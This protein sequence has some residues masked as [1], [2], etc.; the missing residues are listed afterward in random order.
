MAHL[1]VRFQLL[2]CGFDDNVSVLSGDLEGVK[3]VESGIVF[4][5]SSSDIEAGPVEWT[6]DSSLRIDSIFKWEVVMGAETVDGEELS[7]VI[8]HQ[9]LTATNLEDLLA[10]ME[11]GKCAL[12]NLKLTFPVAP[13]PVSQ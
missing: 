11:N 8:N 12:P 7:I 5:V 4:D 13:P 9:D 1:S 2:L 3:T 6:S 10:E